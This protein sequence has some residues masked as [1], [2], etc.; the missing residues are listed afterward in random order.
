[1]WDWPSTC[2]LS[3]SVLRV[4]SIASL[5]SLIKI[6]NRTGSTP[7]PQEHHWWLANSWIEV[8]VSVR[9][10]S[11]SLHAL[12]SPII[13]C[14]FA[15]YAMHRGLRILQV[16]CTTPH[17]CSLTFSQCPMFF[18]SFSY[19][20]KPILPLIVSCWSYVQLGFGFSNFI[21]NC[22]SS[23]FTVLDFSSYMFLFF[24]SFNPERYSMLTQ[25]FC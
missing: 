22:P 13:I 11:C 14:S 21:L 10:C 15:S 24:L 25:L 16:L 20:L 7:E 1:M 6:L 18:L 5:R 2:P 4:H 8:P 3:A 19:V 12:F 17:L 23:S 9:V